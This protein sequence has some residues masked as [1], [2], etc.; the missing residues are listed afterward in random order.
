MYGHCQNK[1]EERKWKAS[2]RT[3]PTDLIPHIIGGPRDKIDWKQGE[4]GISSSHKMRMRK[5]SSQGS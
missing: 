5:D 1:E 3:L 4:N 2:H